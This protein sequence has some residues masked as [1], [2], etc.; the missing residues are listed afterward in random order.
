MVCV[1]GIPASFSHR[2]R[3]ALQ[4]AGLGL[5]IV[6]APAVAADQQSS[7]QPQIDVSNLTKEAPRAYDSYWREVWVGADVSADSWLMYS[8]ATIAP[9]SHIHKDGFR[10][11]TA[12]GY[13]QYKYDGTV[14]IG[15][16]AEGE[17]DRIAQTFRADTSFADVLAGYQWQL[18][19]VTTKLLVG[20]SFISHNI[21]PFDEENFSTGD[22]FGIKGVLELWY[23]M[24]PESWS[25]LDLSYSTAHETATIRA[26]SGYRLTPSWSVGL[27]GGLNFDGQGQCKIR[28][29]QQKDCKLNANDT[30][31]GSLYDYGRVGLFA[32]HEWDG[33]EVSASVGAI[34]YDGSGSSDIE[35]YVTLNWITQF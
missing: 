24:S 35:P 23:N 5:A 25:S 17:V 30:E 9:W 1:W 15:R 22:E 14:D 3:L 28:L 26:R 29:P 31:T 20:A 33:G 19:P 12:F 27:E 6:T 4:A 8:G 16:T 7:D 13:G 2:V 18:G 21:T 10:L 32:R 34:G 11:R